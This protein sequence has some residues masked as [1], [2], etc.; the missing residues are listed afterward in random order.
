M[1]KKVALLGM[2]TAVA[3]ALGWLESLIPLAA[4]FPAMKIGLANIVTLLVLYRF[5]WTAAACVNLLRI[6]LSILLFGNP[7]SAF[8]SLAGA[9]FSLLVMALMKKT[10]KCSVTAVSIAGAVAHNTAQVLMA[11]ALMGTGS[12]LLSLPAFILFGVV[13]GLCIGMAGAFLH[14]H[15]P[16]EIS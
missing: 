4:V 7:V 1:A 14:R 6:I 13:S 16:K 9:F 11:V 2:F 8:Y 5:H 15:L 10:D 3:L 12:I